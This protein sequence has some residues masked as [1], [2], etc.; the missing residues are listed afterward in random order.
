MCK[1]RAVEDTDLGLGEAFSNEQLGEGGLCRSQAQ[2]RKLVLVGC[3]GQLRDCCS[4]TA[5]Q[6]GQLTGKMKGPWELGL[7]L[8]PR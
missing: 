1:R 5:T 6:V 3:P 7:R 4:T 2:A 8:E